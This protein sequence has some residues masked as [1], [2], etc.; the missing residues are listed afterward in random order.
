MKKVALLSL[1]LILLATTVVPVMAGNGNPNGQGNGA[2]AGQGHNRGNG[3]REQQ[4]DRDRN[5]SSN[6]G[7]TRNGHQ[8][9]TRM[10]TPFYLQGTIFAKGAGTLTVTLYHGNARVKQY[11]GKEL[12][13]L[14]PEG[15]QIFRITQG[16]ETSG[17][18]G[19]D[20]NAAGYTDDGGEPSNRVPITF[21]DLELGKKV[22]IHGNLVGSDFTA[23]L[24]TEYIQNQA[25]PP[26]TEEP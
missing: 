21:N 24:I 14:V 13:L 12:I 22:A 5:Q 2:N 10:R 8:E 25:E 19:T 16:D 23:R 9:H 15:T 20:T 26:E 7:S 11:L 3:N 18:S 1:V 6:P 17:T 4:H